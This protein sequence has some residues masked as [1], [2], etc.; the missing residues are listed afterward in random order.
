MQ[1]IAAIFISLVDHYGYGGLFVA[2]TLANIGAPIGSE[3]ILPAAGALTATGHLPFL[4]AT[5]LIAVAGELA[6]GTIGYAVGRF[7]GRPLVDNYGKYVHLTHENL[8]RVHAFFKRYGSFAIFICRF[9]PVIR[10]IVSIPA[11][12]AAMDLPQFYGW[13][14]L[15]SLGFC[16]GLVLLGNAF[17]DHLDAILPLLHKT[18]L[19][20]L[21]LAVVAIVATV[22]IVRRRKVDGT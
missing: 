8:D 22:L 6:G 13:Y 3:L 16:G 11:G 15:G 7:G 21:A 10:G 5:I 19:A 20:L 17:G 4:W 12:L 9:V 18:G 14:F 1:H 2:M